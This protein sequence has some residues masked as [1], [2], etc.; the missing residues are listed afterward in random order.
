M[1]SKKNFESLLEAVP[2]ALVGMDQKG[3]IRFVNRE[4]ESLFGYDR[5]DL[6]GRHIETLVPDSLWHVYLAH[7]D[8][9]FSDPRSRSMGLDLQLRGKHQDGSEF[10]VNV[11]MSHVDTGDVL[12]EFTAVHEVEKQRQAFDNAQRMMA[13]IENSDDA[14]IGK[15]LGGTITTWNP[16]AERMYG[17]TS[18]EAIGKSINI[19]VPADRAG[20]ID[21][22]LDKLKA[23]EA[24]DH[25][26]T[27]RVCKDGERLVVSI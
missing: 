15:T 14:I 16:S 10:P 6:V 8:G 18:E 7:R 21:S 23:G 19:I 3:V 2:D 1:S 13:I 22:I 5:D 26:E 9:Y 20:E 25:Y 24:V 4:T 12:L 27:V 17:Y 11:S